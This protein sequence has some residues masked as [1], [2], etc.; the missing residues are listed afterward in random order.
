MPQD[1]PGVMAEVGGGIRSHNHSALHAYHK[2][3]GSGV[4]FQ[5]QVARNR[6]QISSSMVRILS[7]GYGSEF[8]I[9][10]AEPEPDGEAPIYLVPADGDLS[11][12]ELVARSFG[13]FL[14]REVEIDLGL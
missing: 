4:L 8:C 13:D 9:E 6:G 2:R 7:S 3:G 10:C 12:A 14:L 1:G 11:S 5:T